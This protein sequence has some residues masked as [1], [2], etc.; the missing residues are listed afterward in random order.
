[1]IRTMFVFKLVL[2]ITG[3]ASYAHAATVN[4]AEVFLLTNAERARAGLF[5][6]ERN[7]Q[8]DRA[9][10]LKANDMA[11]KGYY[12][13][14]S[15]EGL[16]PMS[17]ANR[18]GYA[19]SIIGENLVVQRNSA[20]DV[21]A[22]FMGSPGH[23]TNILR[24]DFTE[25]GIAV[26]DG[27]YKGKSTTFTVQMFAKA[28]PTVPVSKP[29]DPTPP[30]S[31]PRVT[32]LSEVQVPV[33]PVVATVPHGDAPMT[34]VPQEPLVSAQVVPATDVLESVRE[35]VQPLVDSL[36]TASST[37]TVVSEDDK[38]TSAPSFVFVPVF[39]DAPVPTRFADVSRLGVATPPIPIGSLWNNEWRVFIGDVVMLIRSVVPF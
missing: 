35:I 7:T 38:R 28:A 39:I 13:H 12:A 3:S 32:P 29:S 15:P 2:L 20:E 24:T 4:T 1:M 37:D 9:A 34:L 14:V 6:L 19:F 17:F 21:L 33:V 16:T 11:D 8:L 27:T 5:L 18:A 10:Q 26:A 23:R 30:I 31:K 22:A 36:S 25:I